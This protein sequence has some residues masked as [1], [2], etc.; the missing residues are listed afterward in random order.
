MQN[1]SVA[2]SDVTASRIGLESASILTMKFEEET[3]EHEHEHEHEHDHTEHSASYLQK[4]VE[5]ERRRRRTT[6]QKNTVQKAAPKKRPVQLLPA[7][8]K[9]DAREEHKAIANE[10]L[11]HLPEKC[12][13][14]LQNW[15]VKNTK[16][17]HRGLA[18]K[19]VMILDGTVPLKEF[20]ALFV[21]ETGHNFDLGC[22]RGTEVAGK[23]SFSDGEESIYKD[24]PSVGFYSISWITSSVQ[25][26]NAKPEDF[27][28][29]Y[30]SYAVFEDFAE[31]FAYFYLHN[32][33]FVRR[34]QTNSAL[35]KKYAFMR[36]VIFDGNVPQVA[37]GKAPYENKPPWDVTK[38]DYAWHPEQVVV[39]R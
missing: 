35:A 21:H 8:A 29:G 12:R 23:S 26:S 24:D 4:I 1:G 33:E 9:A 18:G 32:N 36:D 27:V 38:L 17:K 14:T 37:T 3:E 7:I 13:H 19:T 30:A 16:Q 2:A 28:S 25:R 5:Q 22:L 39:Q 6:V 31:T 34:A 11:M 20:L 15:Y 10:V